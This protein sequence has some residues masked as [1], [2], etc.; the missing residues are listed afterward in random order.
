MIHKIKKILCLTA[1]GTTVF[2]AG[3]ERLDFKT[4]SVPD[5]VKPYGSAVKLSMNPGKAIVSSFND[6]SN[7]VWCNKGFNIRLPKAIDWNSFD[8]VK[9]NGHNTGVAK[10]VACNLL[11]E[12]GNSWYA[13]LRTSLRGTLTFEK[14]SFRHSYNIKVKNAPKLTVKKGKI[15]SIMLYIGTKKVNSG[16]DYK[17]SI[18]S[19]V[20]DTL[21]N[22]IGMQVKPTT[23]N[24]IVF[25]TYGDIKKPISKTVKMNIG[26]DKIDL[27]F[28]DKS[29]SWF[30]KGVRIKLDKAIAW[31]DFAGISYNY[32]ISHPVTMVAMCMLDDRG[33]WWEC[34]SKKGM[35]TQN[36]Y[37]S[38][39]KDSFHR[40]QLTYKYDDTRYKKIGKIVELYPFFGVAKSNRGINYT[41]SIQNISFINKFATGY[42]QYEVVDNFPL[43]WEN[44]NMSKDGTMFVNGKPFFPLMLYSSFGF[45]TASGT[46]FICRYKGPTD[47]TTNR[48]RFKIIKDAGFNAMMSYTL[49]LYGQKVSGPGWRGNERAK[50]P[51]YAG[52][53]T[54]KLYHEASQRFLDYCK[55]TGLMAMIGANSTYTLPLPLPPQDRK[56]RWKKHKARI[57]RTIKKFKNH[58]ALLMWY[59]FDEPS[60]M[61]TPPKDLI[62]TY[63]YA[64]KLD[65]DH[66]FYMAAADPRNDQEY[67]SA[68][69]IVAPDSY[70]LAFNKPITNDT[71]NLPHYKKAQ[72]NG[73]PIVWQIVQMCQWKPEL[74]QQLPTENQIRTQCFLALASNLKGMAFYTYKNYPQ[75]RPEQWEQI[76]NAVNSMHTILPDVLASEKFIVSGLSQNQDIKY[77]MHQV[78]GK[79]YYLLIAVNGKENFSNKIPRKK[80]IPIAL[81]KVKFS[82]GNIKIAKIEALDENANGELE[83]GKTRSVPVNK[84]DNG[85]TDDFGKYSTHAY[86]IFY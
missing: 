64:K 9:I 23:E 32:S 73:W 40:S 29:P 77:I 72:K 78:K 41:A 62:Q 44:N 10:I 37:V 79:K 85:F 7:I 27:N 52:E 68:V 71:I 66:P 24:T 86:K 19:I 31:K 83:L 70:P 55:D 54:E 4:Q 38:F 58:P 3:A 47:D 61:N 14:N 30:H 74:Q 57:A 28:N 82:L 25:A 33:V 20:F 63:Q 59:M 34:F 67:F 5:F 42:F 81:G 49:N 2:A 21:K 51:G 35:P 65:Q 76:S 60:S 36:G 43:Q 26:K 6:K 84:T 39:E 46:Y 16:T 53:T 75:N 50:F 1:L 80:P 11:D 13:F 12:A 15:I 17:F 45:D 56:G 18:K 8:F 22:K 69:D 48:K